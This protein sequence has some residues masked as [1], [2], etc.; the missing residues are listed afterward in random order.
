MG[1]Q[2]FPCYRNATSAW[3]LHQPWQ[4]LVTSVLWRWALLGCKRTNKENTWVIEILFIL[5]WQQVGF[6]RVM[7]LPGRNRSRKENKLFKTALP[8][9]SGLLLHTYAHWPQL[10]AKALSSMWGL[11]TWWLHTSE[12]QTLQDAGR[13]SYSLPGCCLLPTFPQSAC[14]LTHHE[15]QCKSRVKN[16]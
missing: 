13:R 5:Q 1:T 14:Y 10:L 16:S 4:I 8:Q 12:H 2:W 15:Q 11:A 6:V 9:W 3:F 7:G